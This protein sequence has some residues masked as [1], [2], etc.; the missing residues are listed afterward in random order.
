MKSRLPDKPQ[1]VP[2][3]FQP[4][5]AARVVVHAAETDRPRREYWVGSSTVEAI[6]GQVF[7]PGLLD[8][9]LG[10]TGYEAQQ[11]DVPDNSDRPNNLWNYIPGTHGAHGP[12]DKR[13]HSFSP[14]VFADLHRGWFLGAGAAL[15]TAAL[16]AYNRTWFH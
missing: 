10:H 5:V 8:R 3:I 2:P 4:E 6:V 16:I 12:F 14:Q 9:Y 7:I 1:P 15:M 11:I 13:A